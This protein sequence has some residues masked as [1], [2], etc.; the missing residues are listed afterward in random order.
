MSC[1]YCYSKDG[2]LL[3]RKLVYYQNM[4]GPC[5]KL[6]TRRCE[7]IK[8]GKINDQCDFRVS[9]VD[10]DRIFCIHHHLFHEMNLVKK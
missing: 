3:Y 9:S 5:D 8:F 7:W 4:C 10:K 2:N 1:D 6:Y